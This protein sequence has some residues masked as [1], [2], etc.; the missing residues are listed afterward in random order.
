MSSAFY[1]K[2]SINNIKKSLKEDGL[3][4]ITKLSDINYF[5]KNL[6]SS[7]YYKPELNTSMEWNEYKLSR[8]SLEC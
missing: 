5:P 4:Y 2:E 8:T 6:F 7:V 3:E 1:I